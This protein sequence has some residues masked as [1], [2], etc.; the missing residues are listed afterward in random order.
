MIDLELGLLG[1][2]AVALVLGLWSIVAT[3][4]GHARR[5]FSWPRL[6]FGAALGGL[7]ASTFLAAFWSPPS[8]VPLGLS[9]GWLVIAMLWQGPRPAQ[10]ESPL[11]E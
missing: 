3:H 7:I 8:L 11:P 4:A 9:A 5:R 2:M 1:G 10:G 6:L